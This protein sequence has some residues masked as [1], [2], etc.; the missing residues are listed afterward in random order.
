MECS[1][2]PA[3]MPIVPSPGERP[4][5]RDGG[6]RLTLRGR[7][8]FKDWDVD[9]PGRACDPAVGCPPGVGLVE[10]FALAQH[11]LSVEPYPQILRLSVF[12]LLQLLDE[13]AL[14][15]S[16]SPRRILGEHGRYAAPIVEAQPD[17]RVLVRDGPLK[18]H[19][20]L[21]SVEHAREQLHVLGSDRRARENHD[22]VGSTTSVHTNRGSSPVSS[23]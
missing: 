3:S 19:R 16:E 12:V 4:E 1:A 22:S 23:V 14:K 15:L 2:P 9:E 11:S 13:H 18:F 8:I 10:R 6:W 7:T 17:D 20:E 5:E 21:V